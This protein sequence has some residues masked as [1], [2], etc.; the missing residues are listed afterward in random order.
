M[1]TRVVV[2]LPVNEATNKR[3]APID[4]PEA[5]AYLGVKPRF[6][7]QRIADGTIPHYKLSG[8]I[9]FYPHELDAWVAAHKRG[10][11]SP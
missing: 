6:I 7:R 8:L 5:A 10:A 9:R 3:R 4:V 1:T 11:E 2:S